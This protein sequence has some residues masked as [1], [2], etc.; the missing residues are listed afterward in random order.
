MAHGFRSDWLVY[1]K[2]AFLLSDPQMPEQR[3]TLKP[4]VA[5]LLG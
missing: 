4:G 2:K 3:G 5:H 1:G